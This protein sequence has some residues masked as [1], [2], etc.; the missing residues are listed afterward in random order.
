M[1][2]EA[3]NKPRKPVIHSDDSDYESVDSWT[4][5]KSSK[6]LRIKSPSTEDEYYALC[7]VMLARGGTDPSTA[8]ID[9]GSTPLSPPPPRP[10]KSKLSYKCTVCNKVFP[11]FQALGGHKASHRN[12]ST[13]NLDD[14]S[15]AIAATATYSSTTTTTSCLNSSG[16]SHVCS[17]CHK[18]FPTGQA[19]GG[20]KRYHYMGSAVVT[21]DKNNGA[22][23]TVA[24]SSIPHS[25]DRHRNFDLN[26]PASP[27]WGID[28]DVK[29]QPSGD[30]Q[31]VNSPHPS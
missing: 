2:M 21:T 19:L 14:R 10:S 15:N 5:R 28:F 18:S 4:K 26:L 31:E 12:K 3:L 29:S 22:S 16:K 27:R 13:V 30:D 20:H 23:A 9:H 6:R 25:H 17:I 7:L 8:S 24:A 11:A 1:A